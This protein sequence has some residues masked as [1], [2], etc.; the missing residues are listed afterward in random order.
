MNHY[1]H[2]LKKKQSP[3]EEPTLEVMREVMK[4][5][6]VPETLVEMAINMRLVDSAFSFSTAKELYLLTCELLHSIEKQADCA[7]RLYKHS[8][9][10]EVKNDANDKKD[11]V[12]KLA[13]ENR[14]LKQRKTC[15]ACQKVNL[16][17]DGI[18]F[19][20]CGHFVTCQECSKKFKFCPAC[21]KEI[22]GDV[23]TFL[24]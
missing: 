22:K 15:R 18:T 10:S 8:H 7:Q 24:S 11:R 1:Q 16:A 4:F 9:T 13:L 2:Q 3:A 23:K 6:N 14:R 17:D 12:H 5:M 20:P 21:G 19:L